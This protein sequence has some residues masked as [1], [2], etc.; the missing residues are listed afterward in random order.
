MPSKEEENYFKQI[1]QERRE[2][3]RRDKELEA[4]RKTE[5]EG[6]AESLD[7]TREVAEEALDLGFSSE[8]SRVLPLVP[9]IQVAW[10][11]G[12]VSTAEE[13]S[14]LE[15]ATSR[16]I[17]T[18][19]PSYEFL[20]RLLTEKPSPLFFER[21]NRVI[22]R[23]I[24]DDSGA[25]M[26]KTLPE[27]CKEVADASGGFFG[28]GNRISKEEQK[29]IDEFAETFQ[30]NDATADQLRVFGDEGESS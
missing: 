20:R 9:L 4:L 14:V 7:T 6:I 13:Q 1:E 17:E 26:R 10:A 8:T 27:L 3:M 12:T 18:G 28:L 15:M 29:L 24:Q 5:R 23:L 21:T 22:S 30:S 25:W 19:S 2:A 11:D 16:G